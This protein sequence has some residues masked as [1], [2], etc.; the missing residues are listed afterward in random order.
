M[1]KSMPTAE[2][3]DKRALNRA[4]TSE[5]R[6]DEY[7]K[8]IERIYRRAEAQVTEDINQIYRTY[9]KG[10]GLDVEALLQ[11]LSIEDTHAFWLKMKADGHLDYI[12]QNYQ[13]RITRLEQL[14]GDI[15][16][17][18]KSIADQENGAHTDAHT[19]TINE[20][21]YQNIYDTAKGV[22]ANIAFTGLNTPALDA[23]LAQKWQGANY[24]QRIWGNTDILATTVKESLGSALLT[25]K[26]PARVSAELAEQFNV[27]RYVADRLIRTE[28][29]YFQNEAEAKSSEDIGIKRYKYLAVLDSRTSATC[30]AHDDKVYLYEKRVVGL[31]YPPLH[32]N[33]R[34]TT[35]PYIGEDYEPATRRARDPKTGRNVT[36][37]NMSYQQWA[38]MN[39]VQP[40]QPSGTP[41]PTAP[42]Q[43]VGVVTDDKGVKIKVRTEKKYA[44]PV[45]PNVRGA[46]QPELINTLR[47]GMVDVHQKYPQAFDRLGRVLISQTQGRATN[48]NGVY[49][50][51]A[52]LKNRSYVKNDDGTFKLDDLGRRMVQGEMAVHQN[53]SVRV[54]QGSNTLDAY[55]KRVADLGQQGWW[56]TQNPRSVMYHELGHSLEQT[57]LLQEQNL[58]PLY[59][60]F[61]T[62]KGKVLLNKVYDEYS[63]INKAMAR[64]SVSRELVEATLKEAHPNTSMYRA[65][66]ENVSDYAKKS[67]AEAFAELFTKVMNGDDDVV[68]KVFK[69]KLDAKLK[70]LK[71]L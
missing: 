43:K 25:G 18:I 11:K 32:P 39:N 28:T 4:D 15:Y 22:G 50:F 46:I 21:Y 26:S 56:A 58:Y 51:G 5:K 24:S 45:E 7:A 1:A 30:I 35:R 42:T 63:Q 6:A 59:D 38:K 36:I 71:L 16:G 3:W 54:P 48:L 34:S 47:D 69:S 49:Q 53:I 2:Y 27:S 65:T 8:T 31:N 60:K 20:A 17:K 55:A 19:D 23:M 14:K 61:A 57:M 29:N 41:K 12:T 40:A 67:T 33:C 37:Q 52:Q 10:A 62:S 66:K 44:L 70:E 13:S 9:A 68:T 64:H